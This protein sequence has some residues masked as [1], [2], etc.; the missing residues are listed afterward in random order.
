MSPTMSPLPKQIAELARKALDP[1]L[2][3]TPATAFIEAL[4]H[5]GT[6][7]CTLV[8]NNHGLTEDELRSAFAKTADLLSAI[9]DELAKTKHKDAPQKTK[10]STALYKGFS[11]S[12]LEP[13][14]DTQA[15]GQIANAFAAVDGA[16]KGN[17]GP[18]GIGGVLETTDGKQIAR[19][20]QAIGNQTNNI[21]EYTAFITLLQTAASLNIKRLQVQ[22]DS[23][24][25][26]KQINGIYKVKNANIFPLIKQV[27]QLMQQ[28]ESVKIIH[29]P[30]EKNALA[31]ALSTWCLE[32]N[33]DA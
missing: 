18:A 1:E 4:A 33:P 31:D 3:K 29:V 30:R 11:R 24:L 15:T 13:F 26:V 2:T 22:S 23:E 17:P 27:N 32:K 6:G 8:Q 20:S 10:A 21:A 5:R 28:F 12:E 7:I 9:E 19:I 16:C 14:V 25:M